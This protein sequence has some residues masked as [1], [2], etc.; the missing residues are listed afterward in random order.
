M[1]IGVSGTDSRRALLAANTATF[2]A[3]CFS[4]CKFVQMDN[5]ILWSDRWQNDKR[6]HQNT[7]NPNIAQQIKETALLLKLLE[8]LLEHTMLLVWNPCTHTT[9]GYLWHILT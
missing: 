9:C 5:R 6:R 3:A 8:P 4:N 7:N 2:Q 1:V